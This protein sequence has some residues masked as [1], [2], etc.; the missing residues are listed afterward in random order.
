MADEKEYPH[1]MDFINQG[2]MPPKPLEPSTHQVPRNW[3]KQAMEQG[4]DNKGNIDLLSRA[5]LS[6]GGAAA[7]LLGLLLDRYKPQMKG[8][9]IFLPGNG[10]IDPRLY[11]DK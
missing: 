11:G 4:I 10:P 3:G 9:D 6:Y 2:P 7:N 1:R 5:G 8:N